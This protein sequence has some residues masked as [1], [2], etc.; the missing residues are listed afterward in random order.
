M[1]IGNNKELVIA[2]IKKAAEEGKFN[3]KVE[4]DDPN[5]TAKQKN[6]LI[7][8]HLKRRRSLKYRCR[9][10]IARTIINF[11]TWE[12]N[13]DTKIIGLENLKSAKNGAII[14]SN[15]FNPVDITT[16]LKCVRKAGHKRLFIVSQETNLA[17]TGFVG[18]IMNY[19]D[20][21]PIS[22]NKEYM[23]KYFESMVKKLVSRKRY[24]LIYPEQEMWFNYRKPRPPKR[25]AYFYAA[26]NNVPIVPC[27]VEMRDKK[28][29]DTKGFYK[30]QYV[31]HIMPPIYPDTDKS[32]RENSVLMMKKDYELKKAAYEYAYGKKL[33][34][35]FEESDIA[36]WKQI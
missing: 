34:Y 26:G 14:T 12:E 21:I 5:L 31:V 24:V 7:K 30:V 3:I 23:G 4:V 8:S 36:G 25:G 35:E 19:A 27:F 2:N 22:S 33:T 6:E 1:I 29:K 20:I 17:M 18:F 28:E 11:V 9:N 15:H 10:R 13:R 16:I 32:V